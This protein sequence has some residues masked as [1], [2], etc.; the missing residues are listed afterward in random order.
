MVALCYWVSVVKTGS[1]AAEESAVQWESAEPC[2]TVV[3]PCLP[4]GGFYGVGR[5]T[6]AARE[7][8][9]R[10]YKEFACWSSESTGKVLDP[11]EG[12]NAWR[13]ESQHTVPCSLIG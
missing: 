2:I 11:K 8:A 5:G 1:K 7:R 9:G 13:G 6:R 12:S 4:A 10:R 3:N